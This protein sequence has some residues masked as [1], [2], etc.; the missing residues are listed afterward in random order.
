MPRASEELPRDVTFEGEVWPNTPCVDVKCDH[1]F[2]RK[3]KFSKH[4]R[5][6][7]HWK[8]ALCNSKQTAA[9]FRSKLKYNAGTAWEELVQ[10][11]ARCE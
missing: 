1:V 11:L 6:T 8:Y 2:T 10:Y 4:L 3:S 9:Y 7:E 5:H